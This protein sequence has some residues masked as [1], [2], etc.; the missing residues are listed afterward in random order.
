MEILVLD[1]I[2]GGTDLAIDLERSG[3]HV[4][5]VDIYRGERGITPEEAVRR[6]YD[7]L[8]APVHLDPD[9]PLMKAITAPRIT[10]HGAARMLLSGVTPHPM[11]EVTG[12]RG[13]TTTAHAIAHALGGPG[14][15]LQRG[16]IPPGRSRLPAG[17]GILHTSRGTFL[18]PEG[19]L[20]WKKSITPASVVP[21]A[22]EAAR[23]S[24][25]LV[26]EESLGVSGAGDVAVLTSGNDYRIAAGKRSALAAKLE[27]MRDSPLVVVPPGVRF[28]HPHLVNTAECIRWD[29]D[30]CTYDHNGIRGEFRNP[31]GEQHPYQNPLSLAAATLCA[32]GRDP[33]GLAGFAGVEGRLS[34]EKRNGVLVVDN[35]NSGT[36]AETT[37][38]AASYAR[39]I[40]TGGWITLVIGEEDRTV[41]EGFPPDAIASSIRK[42]H[43]DRLVLVGE[44]GRSVRPEGFGRRVAYADTLE[45]ARGLALRETPGGGAVVLSVKTWR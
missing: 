27:S 1:T 8:I 28:D 11:I 20:L 6:R 38:A 34:T 2:H 24:G 9:H 3:H 39:A 16:P 22:R 44:R 7:L 18:S 12:A 19:T 4:D 17:P 29:G 43:P 32:L 35:S 30:R 37:E 10:H 13:K 26:A 42:I 41:C 15:Q 25:W 21:A 31:L 33:G 5:T 36:S 23:V 40:S 14:V 45:A